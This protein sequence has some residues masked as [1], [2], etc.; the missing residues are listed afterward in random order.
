MFIASRTRTSAS[1][2]LPSTLSLVQIVSALVH[3]EEDRP[4]LRCGVDLQ[5]VGAANAARSCTGTS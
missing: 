2:F 5:A 3:A 1:G 4:V